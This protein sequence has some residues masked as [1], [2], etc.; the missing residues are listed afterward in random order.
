MR[1]SLA[2]AAA[3][4]AALV[5]AAVMAAE[6]ATANMAGPD[7]TSMGV[8]TLT[9]G[10]KGVLVQARMTGLATGG[11]GF[12]IHESGSCSPDF[13]AAGDHY[14]PDGTGHGFLHEGG[15]HG[16]DLPNIHAD[17]AGNAQADYFASGV[18]L[19]E[20]AANTLFDDDGSAII[21]H[22]DADSYGAEAG[23]GGRVACGVIEPD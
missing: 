4:A 9:Q 15:Y 19:A 21:V 18:S 5:P 13:S 6:S 3:L 7:G 14:N 22:E 11:H 17:E 8:V 1:K 16:G 10:P 23:A 20:D 2:I 12:H